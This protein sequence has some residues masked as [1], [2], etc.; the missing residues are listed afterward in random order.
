M[1][2]CLCRLRLRRQLAALFLQRR[3]LLLL[4]VQLL[5]VPSTVSDFRTSLSC[6]DANGIVT[7]CLPLT[8]ADM[9]ERTDAVL[10][11]HHTFDGEIVWS[12]EKRRNS[13]KNQDSRH[14]SPPVAHFEMFGGTDDRLLWSV[15]PADRTDRRRDSVVSQGA[16]RAL[17]VTVLP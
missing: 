9:P 1:E 14:T 3:Q 12:K 7:S 10:V 2:R 4:I 11:K 17:F 13:G 16:S 15:I 5:R 8:R 6:P